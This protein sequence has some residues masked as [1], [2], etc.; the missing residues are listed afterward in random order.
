METEQMMTGEHD[1]GD[2]K[3]G[4]KKFKVEHVPEEVLRGQFA[5]ATDSMQKSFAAL[6]LG[7]VYGDAMEMGAIQ[8]E[9]G[10]RLKSVD[11]YAREVLDAR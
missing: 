9:F 10:I 3:I 4:G 11:E 7:Y 5:S 6:A 8:K 1:G 2:M